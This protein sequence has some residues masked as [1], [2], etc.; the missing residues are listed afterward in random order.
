[1][2]FR[3]SGWTRRH[4]SSKVLTVQVVHTDL[5]QFVHFRY[6]RSP[7]LIHAPVYTRRWNSG[8]FT[9]SF[10][11]L[12]SASANVCCA[13]PCKALCFSGVQPEEARGV[14]FS[15]A[16]MNTWNSKNH[17]FCKHKSRCRLSFSFLSAA[18]MLRHLNSSS[19]FLFVSLFSGGWRHNF[20]ARQN[21]KKLHSIHLQSARCC[22]Q[23]NM[24]DIVPIVKRVLW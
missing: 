24:Y 16:L 23:L 15:V 21:E 7:S 8:G 11:G 2:T 20:S 1:M 12:L 17:V 10:V 22:E 13:N 4:C 3:L 18:V 6:C 19:T 5:L 9:A 14:L